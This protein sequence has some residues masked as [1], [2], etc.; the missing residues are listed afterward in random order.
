MVG[1]LQSKQA[2]PKKRLP[3]PT[4]QPIELEGEY[5]GP[6]AV[7]PKQMSVGGFAENAMKDAFELAKG[8]FDILP[9]TAIRI[10]EIAMNPGQYA[11]DFKLLFGSR[12]GKATDVLGHVWEALAEP[13]KKHGMRVLYERP[14]NT[15][16]DVLTVI[17]L[18]GGTIA[19]AGKL[20]QA[21][22]LADGQKLIR[23]GEAIQKAPGQIMRRAVDKAVGTVSGGK[24]DLAKRRTFLAVKAEEQGR[25]MVELEKD[26]KGV[27]RQAAALSDEEAVLFHK[28]RT[29]GATLAETQAAPKVAEALNP[30]GGL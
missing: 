6:A 4:Y 14:V 27:G 28:W 11:E 9:S 26:L 21:S 22:K 12:A 2:E 23:L 5:T 3:I 30:I 20:A 7:K 24:W 19:K 1:P 16:L 17:S 10:K 29:Q 13:Y 8:L 15:A 18:A 25:S